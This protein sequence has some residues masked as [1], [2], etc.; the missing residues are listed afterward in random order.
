MKFLLLAS[1]GLLMASSCA[2]LQSPEKKVADFVANHPD[3][4][5]PET[6]KVYVPFR[7]PQVIIRKEFVPVHDTVWI[8]REAW[9]LDSLISNLQA[10]LDSTQKAAVKAA[11]T[12]FVLDRPVL[13]DTLCFDT[14]G[15]QGRFWRVGRNYKLEIIRAA[16]QGR[17]AGT[18]I[19]PKLRIYPQVLHFSW[20]DPRG[21]V[22]WWLLFLG[23]A[24][25]ASLTW[26]L[27]SLTLRAAR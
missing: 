19:A 23:F 25:G 1:A 26:C 27:F 14:L 8:Q 6:V 10:S 2:V 3:L 15:V 7:V 11:V 4:V 20:Y 17:A 22:W 18:V 5:R 21:W 13:R 12:P 24:A 16:I 9:Q